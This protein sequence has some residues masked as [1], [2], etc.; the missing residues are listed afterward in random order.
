MATPNALFAIISV[1]SSAALE[2]RLQSLSHW[3]SIKIAEG[4]WLLVASSGTTSKEISDSLGITGNPAAISN[5]IV[6]RVESYFG[7]NPPS[8]WDWIRAKKEA[9]LGAPA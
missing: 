5:G 8:T 4:Q 7:R 2:L 6:L 1:S 9:E 3:P